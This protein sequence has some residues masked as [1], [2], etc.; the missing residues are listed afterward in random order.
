MVAE[1]L[2]HPGHVVYALDAIPMMNARAPWLSTQSIFEPGIPPPA[3]GDLLLS[4][5]G[6]RY[7]QWRDLPAGHNWVDLQTT[8]KWDTLAIFDHDWILYARH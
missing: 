6:K 1:L 3:A 5:F 7:P 4:D 2:A 8:W